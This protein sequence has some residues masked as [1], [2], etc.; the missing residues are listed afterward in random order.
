MKDLEIYT[1]CHERTLIIPLMI[2]LMIDKKVSQ[3]SFLQNSTL[4]VRDAAKRSFSSGPT[5]KAFTFPPTPVGPIVEDFFLRL[6]LAIYT[7]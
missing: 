6:H 3:F 7:I 4:Y 1:P 5:T 2:P